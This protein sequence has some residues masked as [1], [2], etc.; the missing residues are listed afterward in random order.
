MKSDDLIFGARSGIQ[1][2]IRRGDLDLAKT[3]FDLLWAEK[4]H[5]AWLKWRMPVLVGEEAWYM[6]GELSEFLAPK[7][8]AEIDW[9]RFTYRLA[10]TVKVKDADA[11]CWWRAT[12]PEE[13][14]GVDVL[15]RRL[16]A[17]LDMMRSANQGEDPVA[18]VEETV[19]TLTATAPYLT[20]YEKDGIDV[21]RKR[22]YAG[23]MVGD[24]WMLLAAIILI[25]SRGIQKSYVSQSEAI[26]M[27]AWK[28]KAGKRKPRTV[29]LPWY[30]FDMHTQA[31]K[32]A[33][34]VF[35]KRKAADF[36]IKDRDALQSVWF[37]EE[38]AFVPPHLLIE[39]GADEEVIL[40]HQ[41]FWWQY[42][43]D[44]MEAKVLGHTLEEFREN[45]WP[46]MQVELEGIVGWCLEKRES[47]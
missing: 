30:V 1:K 6:A 14:E 11:L 28:N 38:S 21:L 29:S 44:K 10:L 45:V 25:I 39:V 12:P 13:A 7:P 20:Q 46:K 2:A 37:I 26:G 43:T 9:R 8:T 4:E 23:G 3:S 27:E 18:T 34:N 19:A 41:T 16:A 15:S 36:L 5:Q 47:K 42:V 24:K 22:I 33:M 17:E 35:M 32:F 40:P 31:G